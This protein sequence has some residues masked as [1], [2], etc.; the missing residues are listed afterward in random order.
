MSHVCDSGSPGSGCEFAVGFGM[1]AT[2]HR[3]AIAVG[4]LAGSAFVAGSAADAAPGQGE[5]RPTKKHGKKKSKRPAPVAPPV[6]A[7]EADETRATDE[8]REAGETRETRRT[9]DAHRAE[10]VTDLRD[11][12]PAADARVA[13]RAEAP[14][15]ALEAAELT[16]DA[17]RPAS[18]DAA[19]LVKAEPAAPSE[20]HLTIGPYLWASAVD[21]NVSV[22]STSVSAGID[23]IPIEE[24]AK[25]GIEALAELRYGRFAISGDLMYGVLGATGSA[26]I[27]PVMTTLTGNV[28]SLMIDGAAGYTLFG[29]DDS[30]LGLEVRSGIRYQRTTVSGEL[31]VGGYSLQTPEQVDAGSD[32]LV[33]ARGVVRPLRWLALSGMFDVGVF[34]VSSKTWSATADASVRVWSHLLISLG[35]RTLTM[36]RSQVSIVMHGPRAAIQLT[37]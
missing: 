20:W 3:L 23:F 21:A 10:T 1:P 9:R 14:R 31:D 6:E 26:G 5:S 15:V 25:Y 36:D 13:K 16:G 35:W 28:S 7:D 33:G 34:G 29:D 2:A 19:K 11:A 30:L 32:A 12:E 27:G 18:D 24:H 8:T 4:L 17:G 37:F 22:G